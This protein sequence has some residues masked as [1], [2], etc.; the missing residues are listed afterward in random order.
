MKFPLSAQE[1]MF[2]LASI[3]LAHATASVEVIDQPTLRWR[4]L[5]V[6][7]G[8]FLREIRAW[9]LSP[10]VIEVRHYAP[11]HSGDERFYALSSAPTPAR[12]ECRH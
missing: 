2:A 1:R 8:W 5:R 3:L 7:V 10:I 12:L 4:P 6:D 9:D 11:Q